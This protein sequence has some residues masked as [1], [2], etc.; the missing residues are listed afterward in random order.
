MRA[1][2]W[3]DLRDAARVLLA[4]PADERKA[5]CQELFRRA[6][7]AANA[8]G[9]GGRLHRAWGN[10]TLKDAARSMPLAAERWVNDP[11]YAGCCQIVL[12]EI[13][14][15]SGAKTFCDCP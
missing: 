7:T 12:A 14:R 5:V 8:A 10:G 4:V 13:I 1:V 9:D 15:V 11:E 3:E 2:G 6:D